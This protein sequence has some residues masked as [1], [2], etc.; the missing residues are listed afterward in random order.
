M[1]KISW[2]VTFIRG[3]APE[4]GELSIIVIAASEELAKEHIINCYGPKTIIK[5]VK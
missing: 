5:G 2:K 1:K 4:Y 3:D